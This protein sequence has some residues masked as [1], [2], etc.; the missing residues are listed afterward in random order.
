MKSFIR[1][2]LSLSLVTSSALAKESVTDGITLPQP[3]KCDA[4]YAKRVKQ[5]VAHNKNTTTGG[6]LIIGDSITESFPVNLAP[7]KWNLLSRGIS[8][9]C[10]GGWKYRGLL[11]RLD[12]SC[13]QLKPNRV[14]ILIGIN[15]TINYSQ[16][17][18]WDKPYLSASQDELLKGYAK[19]IQEIQSKNPTTE[20]YLCSVLPLGTNRG[21]D[22][23]NG[24]IAALN[25]RVKALTDSTKTNYLDLY[26]TFLEKGETTMQ[27]DLTT[28]GIHLTKAGYELWISELS[29]VIEAK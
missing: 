12:I 7:K 28:D 8:G 27:P 10:V 4:H 16:E 21:L 5:I 1:I 17:F 22:K 6:N 14:F 29:K 24:T 3:S 9:D 19:I 13:H 20:I 11:D 2:I 25:T 26:S 23:Y 15:D 18:K